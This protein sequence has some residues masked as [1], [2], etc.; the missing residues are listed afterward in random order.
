VLILEAIIANAQVIMTITEKC[1]NS[2][3]VV[4]RLSLR[5]ETFFP[6][7]VKPH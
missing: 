4:Y 6:R 5:S 7:R 1:D 3:L 2:I